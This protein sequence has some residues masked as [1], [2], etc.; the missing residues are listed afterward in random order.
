MKIMLFSS[1]L[2]LSFNSF[3]MKIKCVP[4][5]ESE[6]TASLYAEVEPTGEEGVDNGIKYKVIK[7]KATYSTSYLDKSGKD[8]EVE[9]AYDDGKE[10]GLKSIFASSVDRNISMF[11]SANLHKAKKNQGSLLGFYGYKSTVDMNCSIV[12]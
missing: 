4:V 10:T 7:G 2:V 3:A 5:A 9:G 6:E 8:V 1:L 12:K 11:F